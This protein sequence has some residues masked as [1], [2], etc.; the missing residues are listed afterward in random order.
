MMSRPG[1][2]IKGNVTSKKCWEERDTNYKH[3]SLFK[4]VFRLGDV[5]PEVTQKL[6]RVASEKTFFA[7]SSFNWHKITVSGYHLN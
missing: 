7:A 3:F 2:S 5:D 4:K 6:A 1:Y